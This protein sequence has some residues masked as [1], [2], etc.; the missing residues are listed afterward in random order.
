LFCLR[1]LQELILGTAKDDWWTSYLELH[2]QYVKHLFR[3]ILDEA[4]GKEHSP[5]AV[6]IKPAKDELNRFKERIMKEA[7]EIQ[8]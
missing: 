2:E 6:L 4:E 3:A 7:S 8:I 5:L 1:Y